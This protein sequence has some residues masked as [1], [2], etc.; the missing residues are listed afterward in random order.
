MFFSTPETRLHAKKLGN[1]NARFSK[2]KQKTTIFVILAKFGAILVKI[3]Q[4]G[5]IFD[6][7]GEK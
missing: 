1:S 4:K 3:G 2:K 5:A 7:L 6:F